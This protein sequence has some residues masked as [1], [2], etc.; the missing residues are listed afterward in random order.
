[1]YFL[2]PLLPPLPSPPLPSPPSPLQITHL[3]NKDPTILSQ[4]TFELFD[5]ISNEICSVIDPAELCR[6]IHSDSEYRQAA[7]EAFHHLSKYINELNSD[8]RMYDRLAGIMKEN[9]RILLTDE[10]KIF[11]W[12]MLLEYETD[13]I[14]IKDPKTRQKMTELQVPRLSLASF[15]S[16]LSVSLCLRLR[17]HLG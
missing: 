10:E 2:P 11:G 4:Q 13:G 8:V 5:Q 9:E 7:N 3:S 17:L 14:H 6:N 1:M 15:D 16:S 12:D